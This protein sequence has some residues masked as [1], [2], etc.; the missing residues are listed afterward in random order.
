MSYERKM[1]EWEESE[2][3]AR[4][5]RNLSWTGWI[6]LAVWAASIMFTNW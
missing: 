3:R 5:S 6:A 1:R 4:L 2:L